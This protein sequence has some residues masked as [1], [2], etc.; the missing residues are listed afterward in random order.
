M[1][2]QFQLTQSVLQILGS[3]ADPASLKQALISLATQTQISLNTLSTQAQAPSG[4]AGGDLGGTYPN[5][6]LAK[7]TNAL[8]SYGGLTLVGEGIPVQVASAGQVSQAANVSATTLYTVPAGGA[9]WYRVSAQAVVTQAATSSSTLPNVGV[10]WTDNDSGVA[11]SATTM[12]PT[13][14]ANAPGAFGLG[15]QMMYV[16]AGTNIQYLT[17]NYASSGATPMQYAVRARLEFLG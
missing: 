17:S 10:T 13:N 8:T 3:M 16:K 1:A 7:I 14:T 9:G 12:T 5:P 2:D 6:T 15:S 11:L 4:A